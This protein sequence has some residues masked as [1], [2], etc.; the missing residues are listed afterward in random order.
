MDEAVAAALI[1]GEKGHDRRIRVFS[2]VLAV[3]SGLGT[4]GRTVVGGTAWP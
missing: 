3:E 4:E 2:A 1:L